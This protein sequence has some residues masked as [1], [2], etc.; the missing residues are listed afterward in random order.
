[1]RFTT[2]YNHVFCPDGLLFARFSTSN[3]YRCKTGRF[4][5]NRANYFDKIDRNRA[6]FKEADIEISVRTDSNIPYLEGVEM[7]LI[8]VTMFCK[9]KGFSD[10]KVAAHENA[11]FE[12]IRE[13]VKAVINQ[14]QK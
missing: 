6:G 5:D 11:V 14:A 1:M 8:D 10:R 9:E 3:D 2:T 4:P 7:Y 12:S 13:G